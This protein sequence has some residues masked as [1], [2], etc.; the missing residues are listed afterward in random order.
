M[1][2]ENPVSHDYSLWLSFSNGAGNHDCFWCVMYESMSDETTS[3]SEWL[4]FNAKWGFFSAISWQD[5]SVYFSG[6][7]QLTPG[8]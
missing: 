1:N 8:F 7:P 2:V 5:I 3:E 4:L 6:K